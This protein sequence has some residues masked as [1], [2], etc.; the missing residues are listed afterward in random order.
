MFKNL[1][2]LFA[3]GLLA[4]ACTTQSIDVANVTPAPER[5]TG[6]VVGK[7]DSGKPELDKLV[8]YFRTALVQQLQKEKGL[9]TVI[10][11]EQPVP[12]GAF[13]VNGT[14]TDV[15]LGNAAA[16][17][18]IGFGAGGQTLRGS[19]EMR[20]ATGA[21]LS[22]FTSEEG[23][24]GGAGIGGA[25]LISLEEF[26]QKFGTSTGEALGRWARGEAIQGA[27]AQK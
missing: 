15:D 8:P 21:V 22:R 19:F 2:A 4:A 1:V 27:T 14:L 25:S 13:L 11:T 18:I 10:G 3:L 6:V 23:Y 16:R 7:I 20:A 5:Y 17:F 26:A 9:T 24:A 12:P